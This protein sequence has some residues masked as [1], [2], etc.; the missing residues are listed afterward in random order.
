MIFLL[1]IY[2]SLYNNF[3]FVEKEGNDIMKIIIEDSNGVYNEVYKF[4]DKVKISLLS[5]I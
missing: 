4:E 3:K 1:C 5:E 2:F